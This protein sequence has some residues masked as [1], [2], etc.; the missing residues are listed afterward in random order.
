M[1]KREEGE[2]GREKAG[3]G[4]VVVG[5]GGGGGATRKETGGQEGRRE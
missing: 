5:G 2:R 1:E 4:G 3:V